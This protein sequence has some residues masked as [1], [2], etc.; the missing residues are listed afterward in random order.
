MKEDWKS[1]LGK[2]VK[3]DEQDKSQEGEDDQEQSSPDTYCF[4]LV[5][6]VMGLCQSEVGRLFLAEQAELIRDL[7]V[8]LHVSTNR[9]QL[10]VTAMI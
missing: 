10:Q 8:L 3:Q 4:E 6:M 7:L 9:I 2:L 1:K 5:S